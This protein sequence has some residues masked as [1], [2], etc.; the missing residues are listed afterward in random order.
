MGTAVRFE[1]TII[2]LE[3]IALDQLSYTVLFFGTGNRIWTDTLRLGRPTHYLCA[4]PAEI[5]SKS[6]ANEAMMNLLLVHVRFQM[7]DKLGLHFLIQ[8]EVY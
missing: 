8:Q 5:I 3:T 6:D 7:N 1:L 2:V 4:M